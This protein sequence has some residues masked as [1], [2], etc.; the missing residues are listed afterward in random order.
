M[1]YVKD[2]NRTSKEIDFIS[3]NLGSIQDPKIRV[4]FFGG[5]FCLRLLGRSKQVAGGMICSWA[6]FS[7]R[8]SLHQLCEQEMFFSVVSVRGQTV[9]ILANQS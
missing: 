9:L 8:R 4:V 3:C 1:L 6:C 2:K 7:S 5:C